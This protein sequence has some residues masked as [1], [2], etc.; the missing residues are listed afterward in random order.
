MTFPS[1]VSEGFISIRSSIVTK[2]NEGETK[3]RTTI[4]FILLFIISAASAASSL[5]HVGTVIKIDHGSKFDEETHVYLSNGYVLKLKS[6]DSGNKARALE[7]AQAKGKMIRVKVDHGRWIK[8]VAILRV[9]EAESTPEISVPINYSPTVLESNAEASQIFTRLRPNPR[10]KSQC[11]NRAHVWAY[12]S[13]MSSNLDSQKVFLFFT[14]R[15][16]REFNFEWWFH[17]SP[18]TLV[19]GPEGAN[20]ERVLDYRFTKRPHGVKEWTDIFMRNKVTCPVIALYSEYERNESIGYCY[21]QKESMYYLQPLDL[22]NLER[23]GRMKTDWL[24]YELR[25]AYRDGFNL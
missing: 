5:T 20:L 22:D 2:A 10:Q 1:L 18:Y 3:M 9:P 17:V 19:K 23:T 4:L 24:N 7:G 16:I 21:L 11:Y 25:R 15:Y 6:R 8:S 14:R 13:K 12:E